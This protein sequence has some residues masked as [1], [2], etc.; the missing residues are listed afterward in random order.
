MLVAAQAD[1]WVDDAD[2]G[3]TT[4]PESKSTGPL[5]DI[6]TLRKAHSWLLSRHGH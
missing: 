4:T 2:H 3:R 5:G 1:L 6:Q